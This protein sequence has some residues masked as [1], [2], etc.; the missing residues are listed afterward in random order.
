MYSSA[1]T[2]AKPAKAGGR[3]LAPGEAQFSLSLGFRNRES[4]PAKLATETLPNRLCRQLRRLNFIATYN[5][6]LG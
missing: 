1:D 6:R 3:G 5:P 2:G 4:E